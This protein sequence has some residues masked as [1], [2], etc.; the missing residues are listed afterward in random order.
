[1]KESDG[2]WRMTVD[3]GEFNKVTS[4]VVEEPDTITLIGRV[5]KFPGKWYAVI[6]L[7]N[8][9]FHNPY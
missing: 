1:M 9:F 6:D 2:P 5:Q 3:Y 7:E 4:L 8:A